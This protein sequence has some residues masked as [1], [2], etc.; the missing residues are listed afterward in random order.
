MTLLST[1]FERTAFNCKISRSQSY[2]LRLVLGCDVLE[3]IRI[4]K[5]FFFPFPPFRNH[6]KVLYPDVHQELF[7]LQKIYAKL[8][9]MINTYSAK[10]FIKEEYG[11]VN[12]SH[13]V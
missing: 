10:I 2:F 8:Y 3:K 12:L 5:R 13:N 9:W 11:S 7:D 1:P 6:Q 4:D